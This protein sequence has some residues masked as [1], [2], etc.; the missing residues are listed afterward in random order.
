MPR[1]APS[2]SL[3]EGQSKILK[4]RVRAH[5]TSQQLSQR[6]QMV[7]LAGRGQENVE[8]AGRLGVD[9]Q[10]VSRWRRRWAGFQGRLEEAEAQGATDK[11]LEA[12][13][14][15][16]LSDEY[17]SGTPPTFTAEQM[18]QIIAIACEEPSA[19]GYPVSHWTPK[20][21]RAE[22]IKRGIVDTISI[23][24]VDRF[25]KGVGFKASQKS[26]LVDVERQ[27]G[28]SGAFSAGGRANLRNVSFS[29]RSS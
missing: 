17:R 4:T 19:N 23:R 7:L 20:E 11:E 14:I 9:A 26:V 10:R 3:S 25:L 5:K 28:G 18:T 24:H 13:I 15:S 16:V 22:A 12:L 6:M 21:V 2:I 1:R 8:I 29:S 27:T